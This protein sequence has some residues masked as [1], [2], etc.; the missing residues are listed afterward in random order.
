VVKRL[1]HNLRRGKREEETPER[2]RQPAEQ[3]LPY[4]FN[5]PLQEK[6][7]GGKGKKKSRILAKLIYVHEGKE[8]SG[9]GR[10]KLKNPHYFAGCYED[11]EASSR[12]SST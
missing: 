6:G 11:T 5:V 12:S 3:K 4:L 9:S 8:T 7:K 1:V 2:K 10:A